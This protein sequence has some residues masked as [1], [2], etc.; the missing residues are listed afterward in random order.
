MKKRK[1]GMIAA[2]TALGAAYAAKK[3]SEKQ[4]A[5]KERQEDKKI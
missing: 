3:V 4:T 5:R 2:G 1:I